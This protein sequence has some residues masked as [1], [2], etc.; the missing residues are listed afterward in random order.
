MIDVMKI[1]KDE[2]T[3]TGCSIMSDDWMDKFQRTLINFLVNSSRGSM[4]L[5]SGDASN[6]KEWS[7]AL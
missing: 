2:W 4:F 5:E 7:E 6:Y 3:K 1:H